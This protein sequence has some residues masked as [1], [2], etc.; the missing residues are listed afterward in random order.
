[1]TTGTTP[2]GQSTG[3]APAGA[4]AALAATGGQPPAAAGQ[5]PAAPAATP[6]ANP[7]AGTPPAWVGDNADLQQFAAKKGWADPASAIESYKQLET[8]LGK[9]KLPLPANDDDKEGWDRVYKALGRPE[10]P[11]DYGIKGAEGDD[12]KVTESLSKAMHELG[13]TTKQASGIQKAFDGVVGDILAAKTVQDEQKLTQEVGAVKSEWGAQYTENVAIAKRGADTFG[14]SLDEVTAI[15]GA[16]GHKRLM[17]VL[18]EMGKTV[19]EGRFV[20]GE[21]GG[22][23]ITNAQQAQARLDEIRNSPVDRTEAL[24]QGSS[25]YKEVEQLSKIIASQTKK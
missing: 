22:G 5:P 19:A 15:E 25:I 2:Q 14:L 11:E 17:G 10:K 7:P 9:E 3:A 20:T 23:A 8:L 12:P 13:F 16:L 21:G 6:P 4:A 18:L 1:M 24:K